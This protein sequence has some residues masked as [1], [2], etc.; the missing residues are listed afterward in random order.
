MEP[1]REG[2]CETQGM[3]AH[4]L[5]TRMGGVFPQAF[6]RPPKKI[7]T[8]VTLQLAKTGEFFSGF[9]HG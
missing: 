7:G 2:G 6:I 1:T 8:Y 5:L 3:E 9:Q 4:S